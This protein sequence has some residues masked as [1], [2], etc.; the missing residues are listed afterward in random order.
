VFAKLFYLVID[1][2]VNFFDARLNCQFAHIAP[3]EADWVAVLCQMWA[4]SSLV[5]L[6]VS[7]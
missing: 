4:T 3:R 6:I 5:H 7:P 2:I 1:P